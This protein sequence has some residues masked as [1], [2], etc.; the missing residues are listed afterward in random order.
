M[1]MTGEK[2][3]VLTYHSMVFSLFPLSL[4]FTFFTELHSAK[5]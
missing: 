3:S 4:F 5:Q 2:I 1:G